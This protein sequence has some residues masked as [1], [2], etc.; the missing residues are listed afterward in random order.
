MRR[1]AFLFWNV[2]P[3]RNSG[4]SFWDCTR[5]ALDSVRELAHDPCEYWLLLPM[6]DARRL[7]LRSELL[8]RSVLEIAV[9]PMRLLSRHGSAG[10]ISPNIL[11]H[12]VAIA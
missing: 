6:N 7:E 11:W 2:C 5:I 12:N 3:K 9:I 8:A 10:Y 4:G 1:E